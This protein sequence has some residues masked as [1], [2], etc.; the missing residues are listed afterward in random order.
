MFLGADRRACGGLS[1][2]VDTLQRVV[3]ESDRGVQMGFHDGLQVCV[4]IP[5]ERGTRDFRAR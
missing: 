5:A 4:G 2:R 3:A 1:I